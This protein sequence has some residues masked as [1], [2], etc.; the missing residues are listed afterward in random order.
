MEPISVIIGTAII[1]KITG[2]AVDTVTEQIIGSDV[3][4]CKDKLNRLLDQQNE[5]IDRLALLHTEVEISRAYSSLE[6]YLEYINNQ[7]DMLMELK[8]GDVRQADQW[9]KHVLDRDTGIEPALRIIHRNIVNE[10]T[11][12]SVFRLHADK[13]RLE[14]CNIQS[15][16]YRL[17]GIFQYLVMMQLKAYVVYSNAYTCQNGKDASIHEILNTANESYRLQATYC[18]PILNEMSPHIQDHRWGEDYFKLLS[19]T[20]FVDLHPN[21]APD[22]HV[23][24]GAE[25][26]E[27]GNRVGIKIFH[28]PLDEGLKDVQQNA[29]VQD[30]PGWGDDE[31]QDYVSLN[32]NPFF[33]MGDIHVRSGYAVTGIRFYKSPS[34]SSNVIELR[35]QIARINELRTEIDNSSKVWDYLPKSEG[36]YDTQ[37]WEGVF[38]HKNPIMPSTLS[39]V[40]GAGLYQH[41]NRLAIR[42]LTKFD[43]IV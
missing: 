38:V 12:P 22:N 39:F 32:N 6:P 8:P 23:V 3:K 11:V 28:A 27:K 9:S 20:N 41:G 29:I 7:Y 18:K 37:E 2:Y 34:Q 33:E 36:Y 35:L 19:G 43:T 15:P 1:A 14:G 16:Y 21:C 40:S 24:V 17:I 5:V 30:S 42:L 13:M 26:Y 10:A 25:L 31:G 4:E